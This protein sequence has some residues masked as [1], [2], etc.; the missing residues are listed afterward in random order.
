MIFRQSAHSGQKDASTEKSRNPT[1]GRFV[2]G[3]CKKTVE[4]SL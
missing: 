2:V 3:L 4:H 1:R